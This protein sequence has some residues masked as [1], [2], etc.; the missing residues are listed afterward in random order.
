MRHGTAIGGGPVVWLQSNKKDCETVQHR[1]RSN[2]TMR[3]LVTRKYIYLP[4]SS[5]AD[6]MQHILPVGHRFNIYICH[7]FSFD[8]NFSLGP[9][10]GCLFMGM[11]SRFQSAR[12]CPVGCEHLV[13]SFI[14]GCLR[15]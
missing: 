9:V 8:I 3:G 14:I 6:Q 11:N 5:A 2:G 4:P 15:N 10:I 13:N 12:K 1:R 7:H